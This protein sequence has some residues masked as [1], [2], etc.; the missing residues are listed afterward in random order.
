MSS[1]TIISMLIGTALGG[2]ISALISY[3]FSRTSSEELR[4]ETAKLKRLHQILLNALEDK[5]LVEFARDESGHVNGNVFRLLP[6]NAVLTISATGESRIINRGIQTTPNNSRAEGAKNHS[7][8]HHFAR[9]TAH[10]R[11]SPKI[12]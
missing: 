9:L 8:Q 7:D 1:E 5:G 12:R 11:L 10:S 6:E 3:C 2:I 4:Q